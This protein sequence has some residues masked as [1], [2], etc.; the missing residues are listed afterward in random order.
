MITVKTK[1]GKQEI[2]AELPDMK[3][4]HKFNR[5]YGGIP[6][7]CTNCKSPNIYL[8]HK[9]P[10][11]NDYFTLE[12]GDCK[13]DANFGILKD[14]TGLFWKGE[15]MEVYVPDGQKKTI[16]PNDFSAP[17]KQDEKDPF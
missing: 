16:N 8:S 5:V 14:G 1:I 7:L 11:G 4:V 13:A 10:G 9:S 6:Q 15:K 2:T 12:C 17:V 3:A